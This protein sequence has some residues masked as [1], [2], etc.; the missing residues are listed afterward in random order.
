MVLV[1]TFPSLGQEGLGNQ[2]FQIAACGALAADLG[3]ACVLPPWQYQAYVAAHE[4]A[5]AFVTFAASREELPKPAALIEEGECFAHRQT[6]PSLRSR[7]SGVAAAAATPGPPP[8]VA[9]RGFFQSERFFA[10][11]HEAAVRALFAPNERWRLWLDSQYGAALAQ[12]RRTCAVHVRRGDYLWN[13]RRHAV[14]A[15]GYYAE[16]LRRLYGDREGSGADLTVFVFSDD[17]P[18]CRQ[19]LPA[20]LPAGAA[21]EFVHG[22][23]D[24]V[25]MWLMA[26][27]HDHVIANSSFS[28]W[29]A[30]LCARPDKRVAAPLSTWFGPELQ[31]LDTRDLLPPSWE[32]L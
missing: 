8:W 10:P 9:L 2:M 24:I 21:V 6:A 15:L 19:H 20:V 13:C 7:V 25:D 12:R 28:W 26:R 30:W 17:I 32:R 11:R 18:W 1:V 22:N 23:R 3:G 27:C 31:H 29:G 14:Q 16:A 4:D 5:A